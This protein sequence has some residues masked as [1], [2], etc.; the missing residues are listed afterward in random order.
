MVA[1]NNKITPTDVAYFVVDKFRSFEKRV[2]DAAASI[3]SKALNMLAFNNQTI[4]H[5]SNRIARFPTHV[6]S[7]QKGKLDSLTRPFF[8]EQGKFNNI[9]KMC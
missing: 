3:R 9:R 2:E 4:D 7:T 8:P 1:W 5:Y 6:I